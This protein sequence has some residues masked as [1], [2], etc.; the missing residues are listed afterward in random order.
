MTGFP[1]KRLNL[2]DRGTLKEN[3]WADIVIFD[4]DT[5]IDN[6]TF[7]DP[8]QFPTG[9]H[10]VIVNGELVVTNDEQLDGLPGKVLRKMST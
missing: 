3:N 9:I 8:H 1:S 7:L 5:I 6:A 10:H 2:P 4:P